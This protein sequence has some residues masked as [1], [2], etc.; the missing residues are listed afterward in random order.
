MNGRCQELLDCPSVK[1]WSKARLGAILGDE[2]G[3][4][5]VEVSQRGQNPNQILPVEGV[6][7]YL[8]GAKPIIDFLDGQVELKTDG[9]VK[10]DEMMQTSIPGIWAIGDIR[11]TPY[12]Q[13]VVAAAD[14]C[15]AAMS[16]DQYL[17]QR[18]SVKPDWS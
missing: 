2:S 1:L 15:I 12:K 6:F 16:I 17:N 11:N 8:Q 10:V 7:V 18:Q 14:G 3:V 13:A 5:A 9:G 4:T